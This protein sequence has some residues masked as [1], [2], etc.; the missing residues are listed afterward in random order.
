LVFMRE[1][2]G[3]NGSPHPLP[4]GGG[5]GV[6]VASGS[7]AGGAGAGVALGAGVGASATGIEGIATVRTPDEGVLVGVLVGCVGSSSVMV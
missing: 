4:F 3:G 2:S 1:T 7:G 5:F 6:G